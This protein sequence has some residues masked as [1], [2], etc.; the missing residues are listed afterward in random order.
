MVD[1]TGRKS[2]YRNIMQCMLSFCA[3]MG[4]SRLGNEGSNKDGVLFLLNAPLGNRLLSA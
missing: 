2:I 3:A 4:D 1:I